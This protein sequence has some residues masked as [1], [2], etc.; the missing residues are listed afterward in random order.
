M[1]ILNILISI[2]LFFMGSAF[3]S[4]FGVVCSRVPKGLSI[5]KPN[6]RCD[7]CLHELKWYENIPVFSYIFLKGRC[8]NCSTKIGISSLIF[9][10]IG[11]ISY[12][13]IFLKFSI[14]LTTLF[15]LLISSILL[16]M[17]MYDYY[18]HTI[19]DVMWIIFLVLSVGLYLYNTL[20]LKLNW[21][22]PLIG[23]GAA[24]L[25]FLIIKLVGY[26]VLKKDVLGT[27]DIIV[28]SISGLFLSIY[29]VIYAILIGSLV[30][31][32]TELIK[33][34]TKKD[35]ESKEIAFLPYLNLGI[36]A[37]ILTISYILN[38]LF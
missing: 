11:G 29:G 5:I 34:K 27:G 32:I 10:L 16:L 8:K 20:Y 31:S 26:L 28:I 30:G 38:L 15:Y 35:D 4:F 6:S 36:Y 25:F 14:S 13:L 33:L 12:I 17:A 37:S 19:L 3:A 1:L 9:E 7:E 24:G 2:Y 18:S 21:Y 23:A 22:E